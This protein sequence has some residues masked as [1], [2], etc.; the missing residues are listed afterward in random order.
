MKITKIFFHLINFIFLIFYLYPGS[1]LG[2]LLFGDISR[3]PQLTSDLNI[4]SLSSNHIYAFV[5]LSIL[6]ML[7]YP[8]FNKTLILY[9]FSISF[10]LELF[11]LVIPNRSFQFQDL[12]GNVVGVLVSI[13]IVFILN[14]WKKNE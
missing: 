13:L 1:I 14:Y 6:G 3:Q 9:L 12:F 11:H 5:L 2:F 4:I 8:K 7:S 10:I